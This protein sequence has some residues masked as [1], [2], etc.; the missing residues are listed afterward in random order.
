MSTTGP[1]GLA[2]TMESDRHKFPGMLPA[3]ICVLKAW[4]AIH[5]GEY[6]RFEYNVRLGSGLDPG[7][8][9]PDYIRT[10]AIMNSQKR[11]DAVG[12]QSNQATIIEAKRRA[13][14]SNIGQL[15]G[16]KSLFI[17]AHPDNPTPILRLVASAVA[18]D[19]YVVA[20][21]NRINVDIVAV[22]FSVLTGR[23]GGILSGHKH[24]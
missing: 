16:Y 24:A 13:G 19:L 6:D 15:V 7:P 1:I 9:Y 4:M 5:Q 17:R 14:Y 2:K 3:E 23:P 12:W 8:A 11:L 21:D 18:S 10:Q 20:E 22:D